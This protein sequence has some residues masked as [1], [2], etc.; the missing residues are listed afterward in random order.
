MNGQFLPRTAKKYG[1]GLADNRT[2]WLAYLRANKLEPKMLLSDGAH[3]NEFGNFLMSSLINR[4]LV[5]RP[6]LPKTDWE[7]NVRDLPTGGELAWHDGKLTLT[8]EG[9]RIDVL[10]ARSR[11]WRGGHAD[12][13]EEAVGI[14]R[15]AM[16]SRGQAPGPWSPLFITRVDLSASCAIEGTGP[17][18]S[19]RW[20]TGNGNLK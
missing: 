14:S 10:P 8:F 18:R 19:R 20:P 9:N 16:L 17:T 4:Y 12:R 13:R 5:Y 3:L 15:S 11:R 1:C 2:D 6:E 7:E